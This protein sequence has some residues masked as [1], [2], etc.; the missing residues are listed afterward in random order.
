M[1]FELR[2]GQ[3]FGMDR[4]GRDRSP[5]K[6]RS[7]EPLKTG[8]GSLEVGFFHAFY[9]AGVQ[10]KVYRLR[11]IARTKGNLVGLDED[12]LLIVFSPLNSAWFE[13]VGDTLGDELVRSRDPAAL[14]DSLFSQ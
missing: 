12:D 7:V 10:D 8:K 3:W 6:I 4:I 1:R 2:V 5:V 9:P 13:W 14:L 11:I